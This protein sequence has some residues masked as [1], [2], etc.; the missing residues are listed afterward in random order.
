MPNLAIVAMQEAQQKTASGR[1]RQHLDEYAGYIQQLP[2]GQAGRLQLAQEE[3][4]ATV[5]RRLTAA[6]NMLGKNLT[7]RR[8]GDDLYFWKEPA[9][10]KPRTRRRRKAENTEDSA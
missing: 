2:E 5:R 10:E 4:I 6:A 7:I 1:Q 8:S 3:K 9:E